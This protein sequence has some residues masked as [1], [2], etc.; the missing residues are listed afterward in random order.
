MLTR[1]Q[2]LQAQDRV[3]EVVLVPEWGGEVSVRTM[4]GREKDHFESTV[5]KPGPDGKPKYN[6]ED[7]RARLLCLALVDGDGALLFKHA[8]IALLSSKSAKA[9]ERVFSVAKR[10]NGIDDKDIDDMVKNSEAGQGDAS[11]ID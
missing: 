11:P 10:L 6:L 4:S 8:D 9:L 5:A 1:E 3:T 7:F 2:I